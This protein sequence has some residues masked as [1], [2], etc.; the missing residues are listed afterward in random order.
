MARRKRFGRLREQLAATGYSAT[1]GETGNYNNYLKGES[2]LVIARKLDSKYLKRFNIRVRPFGIKAPAST[3]PIQG[4]QA[5]VTYQGWNIFNLFSDKIT[6]TNIGVKQDELTDATVNEQYYPATVRIFIVPTADLSSGKVPK[7]SQITKNAYKAYE[8]VRSGAMPYGRDLTGVLVP[9][10]GTAPTDLNT[11][12]EE[13][14]KAFILDK[15]KGAVGGEWT[16][17]AVVF[18]PEYFG[19]GREFGK[20]YNS[21]QAPSVAK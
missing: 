10:G 6:P 12:T 17:I 18:T 7:I 2:K 4:L 15:L 8:N 20:A 5:A 21:N 19:E 16:C 3:A 1:G 14:V 9:E 13:D 11:V